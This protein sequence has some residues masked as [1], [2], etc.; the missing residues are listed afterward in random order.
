MKIE[1]SYKEARIICTI[2][3][4][5]TPSKDDEMIVSMLYA[6][7]KKELENNESS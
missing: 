5:S 6:R 3:A 4:S 7:I 1:F 2:L